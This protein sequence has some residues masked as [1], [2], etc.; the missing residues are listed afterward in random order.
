[1]EQSLAKPSKEGMFELRFLNDER[2]EHLRIIVF[3]M[4]RTTGYYLVIQK[5]SLYQGVVKWLVDERYH[6]E[7][8]LKEALQQAIE[9]Y[10]DGLDL[11]FLFVDRK[12]LRKAKISKKSYKRDG[13]E[14]TIEKICQVLDKS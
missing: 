5:I 11:H 9:K 3:R 2:E 14:G 12:L 10:A 8:D 7:G 4:T 6:V 13:F 1:M